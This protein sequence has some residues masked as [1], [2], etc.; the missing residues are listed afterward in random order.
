MN[1]K[2]MIEV[3]AVALANVGAMAGDN[4]ITN[5]GF[6]G[7]TGVLSWS[8]PTGWQ[9]SNGGCLGW[10]NGNGRGY[11]SDVPTTGF[12]A[13]MIWARIDYGANDIYQDVAITTP[14]TY[15]YSFRYVSG[16]HGNWTKW[17]VT[18]DI[19]LGS[20]QLPSLTTDTYTEIKSYLGAVDVS[21]AD[22][23]RFKFYQRV[24]DVEVG[25]VFDDIVL[26]RCDEN[27]GYVYATPHS[28]K[29]GQYALFYGTV[30]ETSAD[31]TVT[32]EGTLDV[33]TDGMLECPGVLIVN[34]GVSLVAGNGGNVKI[35][36][37][38]AQN[39]GGPAPMIDIE[40]GTLTL[41]CG[42]T[43]AEGRFAT[44]G[45]V[46]LAA[47]S[48]I[49]F[50]VTDTT[51][52]QVRFTAAGGFVVPEGFA[53]EDFVV[54]SD[55]ERWNVDA[56][57]GYVAAV[58][59]PVAP[60]SA[61]WQGAGFAASVAAPVNWRCYNSLG[62]QLGGDMLPN[63]Y[64]VNLTLES[65]CDLRAP[66]GIVFGTGVQMD[67]NG[68]DA[69]MGD[70]AS[71]LPNGT[72][73]N[74]AA[75]LSTFTIDVASGALAN[76]TVSIHGNIKL[77]KDGG[78]TFTAAKA[79][80]TYTGGTYVLN[81]TLKSGMN[82]WANGINDTWPFGR[83]NLVYNGSFDLD[84][85]EGW[86]GAHGWICHCGG[87]GD[88]IGVKPSTDGTRMRGLDVGRYALVIANRSGYGEST[89][90]QTIHIAEPNTYCLSFD[91]AASA[92]PR[93]VGNTTDVLLIHGGETNVVASVKPEVHALQKAFR[94]VQFDEVGDY[95]LVF[96]NR[97]L[98]SGDD[99]YNIFD[100][101]EL[102]CAQDITLTGKNAVFDI[103]G[104]YWFYHYWFVLDGGTLRNTVDE[105]SSKS[106]IQ[107]ILLR[108]DSTFDMQ[109]S[110]AM[111]GESAG[112]SHIEL[113]GNTLTLSIGAGKTFTM[114]STEISSG[115][116]VIPST[117]GTL[118][119][120]T[121]WGPVTAADVDFEV[122]SALNVE[123]GFSVRDYVAN[124]SG[125]NNSGDGSIEVH[126]AFRPTVDRFHGVT[127][128]DGSVLDLR[129][130]PEEAG[131]PVAS[132]FT[133]G[134]TNIQ[135]AAGAAV[136]VAIPVRSD[137]RRLARS[138]ETYLVTW[139]SEPQDVTFTLDAEADA[140]GFKLRKE[141]GGLRIFHS[142]STTIL[143]R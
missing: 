35:G 88:W 136:S 82:G 51:V 3:A 134:A 143:L 25:N 119:I 1:A 99:K 116:I 123:T 93:E 132:R 127:L 49:V 66:G 18:T 8:C 61:V 83:G 9:S 63:E 117:T 28:L 45:S 55:P 19:S 46:A 47:G 107:K 54:V 40:G 80:Q 129:E 79:G 92:T 12:P 43:P 130:W 69:K 74:S 78:G 96:R 37:L 113:G 17:D 90:A 70:I 131:W 5:G 72:V 133:G 38:Q 65:D 91:Y 27:E 23:Y 2:M 6:D 48:R 101:V 120:R 68:H 142:G 139:D 56:G 11:L 115:R 140:F 94:I 60:V 106:K 30:R 62:E 36:G 29:I 4:L 57:E 122:G 32:L 26:A 89:V 50:D 141:S 124:Y 100:D 105:T 34:D 58:M 21:A 128:A 81:G 85:N 31:K 15:R 24:Y 137:L 102:V 22:T 110:Y 16:H 103:G 86:S 125:A 75:A 108:S 64:T 67:L 73:T 111:W 71:L 98:T 53:P 135:F 59:K 126:G 114:I 95:T 7:Y 84:A 20:I 52:T 97:A 87:N 33:G 13:V 77:V 39:A 121:Q 76:A 104:I 44:P 118:Y 42:G 138:A 112:L 10:V 14:G 41:L 109:S